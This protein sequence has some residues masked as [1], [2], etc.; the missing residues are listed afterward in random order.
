MNWRTEDAILKRFMAGES[1]REFYPGYVSMVPVIEQ[2]IRNAIKR[3]DRK[4]QAAKK[5]CKLAAAKALED[6]A[7]KLSE[8]GENDYPEVGVKLGFQYAAKAAI[9]EADQLRKE[10]EV[11]S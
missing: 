7:Y 2:A 6:H 3:R 8:D 4:R 10:A 5:Q 11:A 1:L 9:W